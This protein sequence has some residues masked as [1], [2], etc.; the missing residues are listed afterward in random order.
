M[1]LRM[2]RGDSAPVVQPLRLRI[3]Q[4]AASIALAAA[5]LPKALGHGGHHT[6]KIPEGQAVSLDPLVR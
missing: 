3:S 1:G 4:S 5:F 2:G 6:D